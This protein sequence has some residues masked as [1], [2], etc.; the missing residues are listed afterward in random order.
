VI[1]ALIARRALAGAFSALDAHDLATFMAAWRDDGVFV[2]PGE[3]PQSGRFAG[4]PAVE[5]WFRGFFAQFPKIHFDIHDICVRHIFD[6]V[7]SNVAAVHWDVHLTN[8]EGRVGGNSGVTVITIK[9]GKVVHAK[10]YIF[11][12]GDDFRRNWSAA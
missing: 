5:G 7:G 4:K 10:D 12:L 9:G 8:R 11:D 6:L 3:I 2:Y 1:G